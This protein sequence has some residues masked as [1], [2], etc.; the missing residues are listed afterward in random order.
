MIFPILPS[1]QLLSIIKHLSMKKNLRLFSLLFAVFCA[2]S[3][4]APVEKLKDGYLSVFPV[5]SMETKGFI[6]SF[7]AGDEVGIYIE[8][9][10]EGAGQ[11]LRGSYDGCDW[12]M[13]WIEAPSRSMPVYGYYPLQSG[14]T[15]VL[16][17]DLRR[18]TDYLYSGK[19]NGT[20]GLSRVHME[21]KHALALVSVTVTRNDYPLLGHVSKIT[22]D[23]VHLTG[24]MDI[25]TG[26]ISPS[27]EKKAFIIEPDWIVDDALPSKA[28]VLLLPAEDTASVRITATVDG[29]EYS[30]VAPNRRQAGCEYVY[31]IVLSQGEASRPN[32]GGGECML[33]V[34]YW[35]TFGKDDPV[36]LAAPPPED[37]F[38][39]NT[40]F[41]SYGKT[42]VRGEGKI[43]G[44]SLHNF[45]DKVFDGQIRFA[46]FQGERIVEQYPVYNI[47]RIQAEGRWDGF[48]IPCYV[49][50]PAG[51]YRLKALFRSKG[52]QAWFAPAYRYETEDGDWEYVVQEKTDIPAL[53]SVR[54]E[55]ERTHDGLITFVDLGADFNV[56]Y[57]L[58]N[59]ERKALQG[60]IKAVWERSFGDF[61]NKGQ[62]DGQG[63]SDEIGRLR[64]ELEEGQL[65]FE[66]LI[67]CRITQFRARPPRFVPA[68][69]LYWKA[70]GS[71]SWELMRNDCDYLFIHLKGMQDNFLLDEEG[72]IIPGPSVGYTIARHQ[73]TNYVYLF[74]NE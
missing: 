52:D 66:G 14:V 26:A 50:A 54:L 43:F 29:Y 25:R 22:L 49:N 69:H 6:T 20:T 59:R 55:G 1:I 65:S 32:P 60:E 27:G 12:E 61:Y 39:V 17:V 72:E 64:I 51:V 2:C 48:Q 15:D 62:D 53:T 42:L 44:A 45:S 67:P 68:I 5:V 57:Y 7:Y 34:S 70:D 46:L 71:D 16:P 24:N 63:W 40:N 35:N 3:K 41:R 37:E 36:Q 74:L 21:M 47:R 28:S 19:I 18:Q 31:S 30:Y 23:G 11:N 8:G 38:Q 56:Q 73:T 33:D 10:G 4:E 58:S 9:A 13:P